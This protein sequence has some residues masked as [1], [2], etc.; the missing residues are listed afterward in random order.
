VEKRH[1][2]E[3]LPGLLQPRQVRKGTEAQPWSAPHGSQTVEKINELIT[4][5]MTD[6]AI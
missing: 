5:G 3:P 2:R 1:L 6:L 4:V